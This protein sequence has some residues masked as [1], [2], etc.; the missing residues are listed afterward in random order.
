MDKLILEPRTYYFV[1][2]FGLGDTLF[3]CGFKKAWE[4]KNIGSIHFIIK[5][6]HEFILNLYGIKDYT[7][8]Q[9]DDKFYKDNTF[10][11]KPTRGQLY[12][13]HPE[14]SDKTLFKEWERRVFNLKELYLK[15]LKLSDN[16]VFEFPKQKPIHLPKLPPLDLKKTIFV[17]TSANS[18]P[19]MGKDYWNQ[20]VSKL[21]KKGYTVINNSMNETENLE[22]CINLSL[23]LMDIVALTLKCHKTYCLRSGLCDIL[24]CYLGKKLT[25]IYPYKELLDLYSVNECFS[26]PPSKAVREVIY[27]EP[28]LTEKPLVSVITP[29]FNLIK[30][31][32]QSAF[33]RM[34]KSVANQTYQH[35]EHIIIDG[36][37][38]D[39]TQAFLTK[40][41][42]K[43]QFR[44]ISEPDKGIYDAMNKGVRLAKGKFVVF[45]NSDD[46]FTTYAIEKH[47]LMLTSNRVDFSFATALMTQTDQ[48]RLLFVPCERLFFYS[49]PFC[50]QT[51]FC[52]RSILLKHPFDLSYPLAADL[53]FIQHLYLNNYQGVY[54]PYTTAVYDMN[55]LSG[56]SQE[57]ALSE[58]NRLVKNNLQGRLHLSDEVIH[59]L[60]YKHAVPSTV[61]KQM[62]SC[63]KQLNIETF[64]RI[65]G[66]DNIPIRIE[67][68]KLFSILPIT[69]QTRLSKKNI[70]LF[71]LNII[72]IKKTEK[73]F[74]LKLFGIPM[75]EIKRHNTAFR[76]KLFGLL[77]ILSYKKTVLQHN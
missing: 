55:G 45:M 54:V 69:I 48:P 7:C 16:S 21:L 49:M 30:N 2:P 74:A 42:Q 14:Y 11:N 44:F 20:L 8:L 38:D 60:V 75:V 58:Y 43:Y 24:A 68:F 13:A 59:N 76:V 73:R 28:K 41:Q 37:S 40:L 61:L 66:R 51:L 18:V 4:T 15:L 17:S 46:Y 22:G 65:F 62:R 32:R 25:V 9:L 50:H 3:L 56:Q 57:K 63:V 6:S 26:L 10:S 29:T 31:K 64:Y 36:H 27:Q 71:S 5:K 39:T 53:N 70:Q 67:R 33:E 52:K 47:V 1:S 34:L 72:K 12:I 77:N 35:I 19:L 23:P